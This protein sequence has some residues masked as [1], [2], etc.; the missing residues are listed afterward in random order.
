MVVKRPHRNTYLQRALCIGIARLRRQGR[1]GR[2]ELAHIKRNRGPDMVAL[3]AGLILIAV[4]SVAVTL[5]DAARSA[6]WRG[7]AVQRRLVWEERNAAAHDRYE[8][9]RP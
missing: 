3:A 6:Y 5:V 8:G 4:L 2:R 1:T 7:V 9:Q